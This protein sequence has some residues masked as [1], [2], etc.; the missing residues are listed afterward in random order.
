MIVTTD[1]QRKIVERINKDFARTVARYDAWKYPEDAYS[2]LRDRFLAPVTVSA[3]DIRQ[4]LVWKYGHWRKNGYPS[5]H[6][7]LIQKICREWP[8][9]V[10][11]S[12][13]STVR[14]DFDF[15][16]K[17]LKGH[18]SFITVCF[19]VHLVHSDN[20]AILDQHNYRAMNYLVGTVRPGWVA[21][22]KPS[23][24]QDL[25]NVSDFITCI[26]NYWSLIPGTTAPS[27]RAIDKYLM[28][29][30]QRLKRS[31]CGE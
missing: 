6:Q 31:L 5:S 20:V 14:A 10:A 13:D 12:E 17:T 3:D 9:F 29:S 16:T 8:R 25:C 26:S 28:V 11:T 27:K 1:E 7:A 15:W 4:A 21:K 30:G 18:H 24:F 19:L 22:K 2:G 23:N